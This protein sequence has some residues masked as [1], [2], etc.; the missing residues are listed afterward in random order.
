MKSKSFDLKQAA[1]EKLK[2]NKTFDF[3][4]FYK[5]ASE[6]SKL[7]NDNSKHST[8]NIDS[9]KNESNRRDRSPKK[10]KRKHNQE[11]VNISKINIDMP[12]NINNVYGGSTPVNEFTATSTPSS[13]KTQKSSA[14]RV[15]SIMKTKPAEDHPMD[16]ST[17]EAAFKPKKRNKSVSFMLEDNDEVIIKKTKSDDSINQK[18]ESRDR[19]NKKKNTKKFS[20]EK[21]SGKENKVGP[22]EN[23]GVEQVNEAKTKGKDQKTRLQKSKH[24]VEPVTPSTDDNQRQKIKSKFKKIKKNK[25]N[26][27]DKQPETA[28]VTELPEAKIKKLKKKKRHVKQ[29]HPETEVEGEPASKFIKKDIAEDL[30][31]LNIGDNAHTLTNL[32]DEMT[33]VDKDKKKKLRQKFNKEKKTSKPQVDLKKESEQASEEVKEKVKW[34]KR[35]WNKDKKGNMNEEAQTHTVIVENLPISIMFTYKKLLSEHFGKYGVIKKIGIAEVY[36]TEESKPVFTTTI[37]FY[38]DGSA[39]EAL[40]EDNTT[41]EGSRIRVKHPLPPTETTLVIRSYAELS[42]QSVTSLLTGAGRIRNIR[43][44]VKGKKSMSTA[45][46]EFDG[47]ESVERAMKIASKAKVGGKRVHVA[48]FEVRK[49]KEK[50]AKSGAEST[51]EDSEDSND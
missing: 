6:T 42:E 44:L 32:L 2:V 22:N 20:V 10:A 8:N 43:L 35:K 12:N 37:H 48:K 28:N 33:V 26:E 13:G 36:P 17:P 15:K 41:F 47:P 27:E 46:V 11:A 23:M 16:G 7:L 19:I 40:K 51:G 25:T 34:N 9:T 24:T 14:G 3:V 39:T 49:R 4:G 45:F 21:I 1:P 30:E 5:S 38:S 29:Q 31:N 18:R 50:K